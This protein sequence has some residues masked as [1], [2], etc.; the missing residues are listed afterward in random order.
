MWLAMS[1]SGAQQLFE[2]LAAESRDKEEVSQGKLW[3]RQKLKQRQQKL[4]ISFPLIPSHSLH[5]SIASSP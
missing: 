5:S 1:S 4:T 3:L 2:G